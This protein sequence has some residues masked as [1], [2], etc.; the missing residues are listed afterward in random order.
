[1]TIG[2][3]RENG[4]VIW[5]DAV[6]SYS[7]DYSGQVTQHP[8]EDGSNISD[9]FV[10]AN[11]RFQLQG[12]IS[13]ADFH[14]NRPDDIDGN[15]L[16]NDEVIN[17]TFI[18][19]TQTNNLLN[20]LPEQIAGLLQPAQDVL[21]EVRKSRAS[22]YEAIKDLLKEIHSKGEAVTILSYRN[23]VAEK[24]R[25]SCIITNLSIPETVDTGEAL[26]VSLTIEKIKIATLRVGTSPKVKPIRLL[27]DQAAGLQR[28]G[29]AG[30]PSGAG[31]VNVEGVDSDN[32]FD[33]KNSIAK[34]LRDSALGR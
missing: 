17:Q 23:G 3:K 5:F 1:M 11:E 22:Q 26:E 20:L 15:I 10:T 18:T 21:V 16:N 19:P 27:Q 34:R 30:T 9:N 7:E 25:V 8:V 31:Q 6:M 13:D 12:I 29:G 14:L 2:I 4:D 32:I 24:P 28:A 33:P